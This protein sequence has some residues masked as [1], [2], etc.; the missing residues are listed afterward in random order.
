MTLKVFLFQPFSSRCWVPVQ[1][2]ILEFFQNRFSLKIY[3]SAYFQWIIRNTCLKLHLRKWKY[4]SNVNFSQ[5][6]A[7]FE[8]EE[9]YIEA[10]AQQKRTR[11]LSPLNTFTWLAKCRLH[12]TRSSS[13]PIEN[14]EGIFVSP[15]KYTWLRQRKN[16]LILSKIYKIFK[17]VTQ[18]SCVHLVYL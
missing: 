5:I 13:G 3:N 6:L 11:A 12:L 4:I 9:Y 7:H 2:N 17:S 18:F 8:N 16:V 10:N 1:T 15:W 14:K